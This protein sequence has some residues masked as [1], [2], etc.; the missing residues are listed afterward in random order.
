MNHERRLRALRR[1]MKLRQMDALL[2]THLPDVRYLCGFTGSNAA[3]GVSGGRAAL[4]TDGRYTVQ[5]QQQV[6]AARV[7]IAKKPA[8]REC[9]LWLEASGARHTFFD[10]EH[11]TVSQLGAMRLALRDGRRR[12]G[13][14]VA[15]PAPVVATHRLVKDEDEIAVMREAALL[16]CRLFEELLEHIGPGVTEAAIAARLEYAARTAGAEGMSFETIVASGGRSALPHGQ[17]SAARLPR[18]GFVT[19]DFGVILRGYCS[20]MTRTVCLG[21]ARGREREAYEAVLE[22]Q[23]SAVA[24]VRHGVSCG[25]VDQAARSVLERA[26]L[27]EFFSHSTGH[28]V[29]IEIHEAP[30]IAAGEKSALASGMVVA[31]EPGVYLAGEFG[32][33][34]EDMVLV[35][36][37][38]GEILTPSTKA[39]ISL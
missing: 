36:A 7:H 18:N 38:G 4:F 14:F 35:T 2:V 22:A 8:L 11:T 9:C 6:Q 33:R 30:R 12:R 34:I 15:L 5:A 10:P 37:G 3:L 26:G 1:S 39:L 20:D 16:G 25:E 24:A 29:G 31:I 13:F 23:Q 21:K 19:L 17:A 32:L 28:G 27:G